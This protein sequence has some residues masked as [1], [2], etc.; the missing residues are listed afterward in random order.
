MKPRL[1]IGS[2]TDSLSVAYAIQ[3]NLD[4]DARCKVWTQGVFELSKATIETLTGQLDVMDYAVFVFTPDDVARIRDKTYS[5][6]RDNV[7]FEFGL[8]VGHLGRERTYFVMPRGTKNFRIPSDLLGVEPATYDPDRLSDEP[9]AALGAACNKI[10]RAIRKSA[11]VPDGLV[12]DPAKW[13]FRFPAKAPVERLFLRTASDSQEDLLSRLQGCKMKFRTFGLTRNFY[14]IPKVRALI[15]SLSKRVPVTLFLMDPDCDSRRDRY[16][17]E[18]IEAA[19]E[20]PGRF[21]KQVLKPYAELV[22][23]AQSRKG[24]SKK[25]LQMFF[26]NFPCSFAIEEIDES[27]RVMLYG[28]GKRG[29]EGPILVLRA[30]NPYYE[31]FVDQLDWFEQMALK[32]VTEPWKSNGIEFRSFDPARDAT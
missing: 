4:R 8:F 18:P 1:F 13:S 26:Y 6:A 20:D 28:H 32:G 10:R 17:I 16:R 2:S 25:G 29:T 27:C 23:D 24:R 15:Q 22:R 11:K 5:Q 3:E 12:A 30:G 14:A 31:Y 19:L 9:V 7:L 21:R